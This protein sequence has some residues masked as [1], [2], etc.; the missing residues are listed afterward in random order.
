M[1]LTDVRFENKQKKIAV[2]HTWK[3]HLFLP[4]LIDGLSTNASA[5]SH[6][7]V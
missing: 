4:V 5:A 7:G 3:N 1:G 2:E 6:V